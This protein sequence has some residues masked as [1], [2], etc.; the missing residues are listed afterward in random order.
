MALNIL[1]MVHTTHYNG[2]L[3]TYNHDEPNTPLP[4][5]LID[6]A[7]IGTIPQYYMVG[8]SIFSYHIYL[9]KELLNLFNNHEY[10]IKCDTDLFRKYVHHTIFLEF[11][12]MSDEEFLMLKLSWP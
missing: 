4:T 5:H 2:Q 9:K 10:L 7:Y 8:S 12:N 3:T 1:Q 11:P 6:H